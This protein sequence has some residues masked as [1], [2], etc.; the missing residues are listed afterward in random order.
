MGEQLR[1]T[2]D[3]QIEKEGFFTNIYAKYRALVD[4]KSACRIGMLG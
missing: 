4:T 3:F 2:W 1:H